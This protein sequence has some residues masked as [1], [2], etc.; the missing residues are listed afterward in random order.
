[1][2]SPYFNENRKVKEIYKVLKYHYPDFKGKS[3]TKEIIYSRLYKGKRYNDGTMR[4]LLSA[5]S[6]IASEFIVHSALDKK[7][8]FQKDLILL[9][10]YDEKDLGS[11]FLKYV[12][13]LDEE[14]KKINNIEDDYFKS[15]FEIEVAKLNFSLGRGMG[16]FEPQ[17]VL[18]GLL[19]CSTYLICYCLITSFKLNQDILVTGVSYD[20]DYRNTIAYKFIESLGPEKFIKSIKEFAPEFYPVVAIYFS[21]FMIASTQH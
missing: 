11:L 16:G 14:F 9:T 5:V 12:S 2:E 20:L 17:N 8:T 10:G 21:R 18:S 19:K 15:N 6:K 7:N 4:K 13:S 3:F 1:V